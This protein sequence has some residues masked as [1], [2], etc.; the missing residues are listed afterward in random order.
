MWRKDSMHRGRGQKVT[1]VSDKPKGEPGTGA[2]VSGPFCMQLAP[3]GGGGAPHKQPPCYISRCGLTFQ[4]LCFSSWQQVALF[5]GKCYIIYEGPLCQNPKPMTTKPKDHTKMPLQ[6]SGWA[7]LIPNV[8]FPVSLGKQD[9]PSGKCTR[10]KVSSH[11]V[12]SDY[13]RSHGLLCHQ[14]PLSMR[15][16]RQEYLSG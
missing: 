13:L 16:S 1:G 11:S 2:R 9:V 15:F 3:R 7:V 6:I 8:L 4:V 10:P 5:Q 12:V 14:A